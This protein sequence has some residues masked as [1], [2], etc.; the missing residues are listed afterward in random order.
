MIGYRTKVKFINKPNDPS[1]TA[2]MSAADKE[3]LK[4]AD[5]KVAAVF[6]LNFKHMHIVD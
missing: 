2:A 5:E 4:Q 3:K 6:K 1:G